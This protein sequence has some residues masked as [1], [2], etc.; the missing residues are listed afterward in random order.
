MTRSAASRIW[1][2]GTG[3]TT[4]LIVS[5]DGYVLS[6]AFNFINQ[7]TSILVSLPSGKRAAKYPDMFSAI[8]VSAGPI[9]TAGYPFDKL[10]DKVAVMMLYGS[11]D[12]QSSPAA[13]ERV[14]RELQEHGV[15]AELHV[16]PNGEHLTAY[17]DYA[18]EI[19][20]FLDRH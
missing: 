19:F 9:V 5:E 18:S 7:P 8:V 17:L 6:S 2:V 15:E 10:K 16:V 12:T 20:D 1:L 13:S 11:A 3:P 14:T 4:G